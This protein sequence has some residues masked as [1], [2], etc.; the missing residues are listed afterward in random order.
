MKKQEFYFKSYNQSIYQLIIGPEKNI[1]GYLQFVCDIYDHINRYEKIMTELAEYGYVCFGIDLPGHGNSVSDG[2]GNMNNYS[3][4]RLL[5]DLHHSYSEALKKYIPDF[6]PISIKDKNGKEVQILKPQLHAMIGI[7]FGCSVIRSYCNN[8]NDTNALVFIGD[9]GFNK[10][11]S[12]LLK[13]CEKEKKVMGKDS[14]SVLIRQEIQKNYNNYFKD[15]KI[16]RNSYRVSNLRDIRNINSDEGCN[17]E[18]TLDSMVLILSIMSQISSTQWINV[19]P[20]YMPLYMLSGYD[21]PV[22]NYT[23]ELDDLL[24]KLRHT[25]SKNIF[26]KYYEHCRHEVLFESNEIVKDLKIYFDSIHK[27]MMEAY[28]HNLKIIK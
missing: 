25:T 4:N 23:R 26:H 28:K 10:K 6:S 17:F 19:Y 22:N 9:I 14:S 12:K 7:G 3:L 8:F 27:S 16:Y 20:K 11:Y 21:D 15:N 24:I 2:Y 1:K 13:C 5:S 18:Y